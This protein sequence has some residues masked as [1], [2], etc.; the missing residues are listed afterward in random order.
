MVH[1][2]DLNDQDANKG[3]GTVEF[4]QPGI[5]F[6]QHCRQLDHRRA[7]QFIVNLR[8]LVAARCDKGIMQ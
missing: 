7:F 3:G 2:E 6:S 4:H 5:A 1:K 8:E